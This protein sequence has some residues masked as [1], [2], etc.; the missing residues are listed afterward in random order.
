MKSKTFAVDLAKAKNVFEIDVSDRPG[1][2]EMS[3]RLSR[4]K[5]TEFFAKQ[6]PATMM[7][8]A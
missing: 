4:R 2:V 8:E 5:F 7:M 3:H 1:H 6:G